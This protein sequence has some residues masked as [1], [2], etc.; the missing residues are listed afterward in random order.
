MNSFTRTQVQKLTSLRGKYDD[1]IGSRGYV[2]E[3]IALSHQFVS[4]EELET[5][6]KDLLNNVD[7]ISTSSNSD[8][9]HTYALEMAAVSA[10]LLTKISAS[11]IRTVL[12]EAVS[13]LDD[14]NIL[15]QIAYVRCVLN[16]CSVD[17]GLEA[18]KELK[19]SVEKSLEELCDGTSNKE[20]KSLCKDLLDKL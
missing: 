8:A 7:A 12:N 6:L 3:G 10:N 14:D 4:D 19:A 13:S 17:E 20:L 2:A 16:F 9:R 5:Y 1:D 15:V 18:V 11:Q